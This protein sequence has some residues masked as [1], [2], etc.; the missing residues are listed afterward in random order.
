MLEYGKSKKTNMLDQFLK[1][2]PINLN[3]I[4]LSY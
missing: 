4:S 1:S 3:P 2:S